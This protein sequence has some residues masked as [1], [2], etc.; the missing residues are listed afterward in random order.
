MKNFIISF[1]TYVV[2]LIKMVFTELKSKINILKKLK[3]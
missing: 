2:I 1:I 3:D